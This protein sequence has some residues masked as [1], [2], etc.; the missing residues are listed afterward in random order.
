MKAA[1]Q[2]ELAN[3]HP[4]AFAF[5]EAMK[6]SMLNRGFASYASH[7]TLRMCTILDPRY[8][9]H[10]FPNVEVVQ[11]ATRALYDAAAFGLP[12]SDYNVLVCFQIKKGLF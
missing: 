10:S 8:K 7:T 12:M 3:S 4:A 2:T 9:T 6:R 5:A 11:E 1:N